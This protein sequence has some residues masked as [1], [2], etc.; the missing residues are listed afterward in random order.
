MGPD[1][2]TASLFPGTKALG[3]EDRLVAPNFV[4]RL[5]AWRVTFTFPL[6]NAGGTV[7]F[8]VT[9]QDKAERVSEIVEG[10]DYPAGRVDPESGN[11]VW[12]LD[13]AAAAR[14]PTQ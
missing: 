5:N 9:G 6:I 2:H 8:L 11:L 14:L 13:S 1:G 4:D 10:A 12:L 3:I 7:A